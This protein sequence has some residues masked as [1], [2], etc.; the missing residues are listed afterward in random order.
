MQTDPIGYEDQ[1]NLYAYVHNDPINIVDPTG[2]T[3]DP[4]NSFRT[5]AK[6]HS[7]AQQKLRQDLKGTKELAG[8]VVASEGVQSAGEVLGYIPIPQAQAASKAINVADAFLNGDAS[9]V[10]VDAAGSLAE[11]ATGNKGKIVQKVVS[12]A[13][14]KIASSVVEAV[15]GEPS[16]NSAPQ[17][18]KPS[19]S[20]NDYGG[21]CK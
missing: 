19:Y 12:V 5:W 14:G 10:A 3:S 7:S 21:G 15:Q 18:M 4:L 16:G 13:A 6:L 11:A 20:G 9:G 1:M 2:K 17:E 8:D